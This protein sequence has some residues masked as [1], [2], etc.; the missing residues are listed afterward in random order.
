MQPL[1]S[2]THFEIPVDDMQRAKKFYE[3]LF[4]WKV[5]SAGPDFEDYMLISTNGISGGFMKRTDP[6]QT[7]INYIN[8]ENIDESLKKLEELG[9][10]ILMPKMPV[11]G[12]GWNAVVKDTENN[13]FGLWQDDKNAA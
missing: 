4:G 8:V 1:Y 13:T 5:T 9:G 3:E 6:S 7:P 12:L 11:K 10:T 2:P